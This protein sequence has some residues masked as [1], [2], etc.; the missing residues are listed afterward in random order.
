MRAPACEH[1]NCV[2]ICDLG[3]EVWVRHSD[4]PAKTLRFTVDEWAVFLDGVER[5]VE[6]W[7]VAPVQ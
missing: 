7:K 5:P 6:Q 3:F 4:E 2:E 1:T